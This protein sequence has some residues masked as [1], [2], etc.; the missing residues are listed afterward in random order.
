MSVYYG[1][2]KRPPPLRLSV[3]RSN[4]VRYTVETNKPFEEALRLFFKR[5]ERQRVRREL[6]RQY[7]EV[8]LDE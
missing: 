1:A 8:G 3:E 5:G 4:G 6:A 7:E 2:K